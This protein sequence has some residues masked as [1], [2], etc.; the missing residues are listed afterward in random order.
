MTC[1]TAAD[2]IFIPAVP[3]FS[4]SDA[5]HSIPNPFISAFRINPESDQY[6]RNPNKNLQVC[7]NPLYHPSPPPHQKLGS[8]SSLFK[9]VTIS[10]LHPLYGGHSPDPSHHYL[11]PELPQLSLCYS[12]HIRGLIYPFSA[13][14]ERN[15]LLNVDLLQW[16]MSKDLE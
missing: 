13:D 14:M 6:S 8:E 2:G 16:H 11:S 15:M 7:L 5:P 4:V 10:H 12:S 1:H 3:L 9:D